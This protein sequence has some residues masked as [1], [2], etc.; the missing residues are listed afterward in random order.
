L[1]AGMFAEEGV[2]VGPK[3]TNDG[4]AG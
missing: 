1:K 4:M 2:G 3:G